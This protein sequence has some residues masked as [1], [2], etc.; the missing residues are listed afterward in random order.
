MLTERPPT[1]NVSPTPIFLE[2]NV[3]LEKTDISA[4]LQKQTIAEFNSKHLQTL[5]WELV[6]ESPVSASKPIQV[7]AQQ[8]AE[9]D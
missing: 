5:M 7:S 1:Q 8:Q 3:L 2:L 4:L 9:F 6:P